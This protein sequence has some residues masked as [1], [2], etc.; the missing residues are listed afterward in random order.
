MRRHADA[1]L[2]SVEVRSD[3]PTPTIRVTD[4]GRGFEPATQVSG[5]GLRS[6]EERVQLIGGELSVRSEPRNGTTVEVR[7]AAGDAA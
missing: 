1:T 7:L 3:G 2:I 5:Y 6:M 4:N